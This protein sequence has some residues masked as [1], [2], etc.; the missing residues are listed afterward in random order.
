MESPGMRSELEQLNEWALTLSYKHELISLGKNLRASWW[1]WW[2]ERGKESE[3]E[4]KFC[5]FWGVKIQCNHLFHP[6]SSPHPSCWLYSKFSL[7]LHKWVYLQARWACTLFNQGNIN[8]IYRQPT[9]EFTS[10][11][12]KEQ[13]K[14][15]KSHKRNFVFCF[16]CQ[17][18]PSECLD[19]ENWEIF[20]QSNMRVIWKGGITYRC[21]QA[22]PLY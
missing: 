10:L 1:S 11:P 7:R 20:W 19:A 14:I 8:C 15:K 3:P 5:P 18:V 22:A 6:F 12:N 17:M 13:P 16:A 2:E 9:L 4:L 21:V